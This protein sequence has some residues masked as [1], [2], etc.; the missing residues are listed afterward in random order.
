PGPAEP[1]EEVV[2]FATFSVEEA[3]TWFHDGS[4]IPRGM[5]PIGNLNGYGIE[6]SAFL[7]LGCKGKDRGQLFAFDHG[8]GPAGL[9]P[10]RPV[11]PAGRGGRPAEDGRR[12]AGRRHRGQGPRRRAL[13]AGR[14]P[15]G[16]REYPRWPLPAADGAGNRLR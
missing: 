11:R 14:V 12:A 8:P 15:D 1:E 3:R 13:R 16:A 6:G 2:G 10:A 7:L 4:S 5:V 9:P